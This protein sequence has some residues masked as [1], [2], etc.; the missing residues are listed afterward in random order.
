MT[1]PRDHKGRT[2][3]E[4]RADQA[5]PAPLRVMSQAEVLERKRVHAKLRGTPTPIG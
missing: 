3:A 4:R 2:L 1:E 5:K